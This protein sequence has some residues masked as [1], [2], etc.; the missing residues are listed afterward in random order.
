MFK[1]QKENMSKELKES[2]SL[3]TRQIKVINSETEIIKQP[4]RNYEVEKHSI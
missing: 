2:V 4:N 3:V 1:V